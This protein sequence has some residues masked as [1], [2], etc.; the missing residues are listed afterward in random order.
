MEDL[1]YRVVP[2]FIDLNGIM[3]GIR[4]SYSESDTLIKYSKREHS[5]VSSAPAESLQLGTSRLYKDYENDSGLI[6]DDTEG[7]YWEPLNRKSSGGREME[8]LKKE[9]TKAPSD[10]AY[11][12]IDITWRYKGGF[13]LYCASIAPKLIRERIRQMERTDPDYNFMTGI[14]KPASF[15]EQLGYDVGRQIEWSKDLK[16]DSL[17]KHLEFSTLGRLTGEEYG[18]FINVYHGPII[19]LEKTRAHEFINYASERVGT[20][21]VLFVKD[22]KYEVQQEYRFVVRIPFHS[23]SKDRFLLNVSEEL[24]KF[25]SPV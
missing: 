22:K 21:V 2:R 17:G 20:R 1:S 4:H 9:L 16:C 24:K 3:R 8:A 10:W 18:Y 7:T 19:Y 6:G 14:S 23:P 13:W 15:A 11:S 12:K 5:P 25:M